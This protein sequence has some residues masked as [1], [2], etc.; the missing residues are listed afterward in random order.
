MLRLP[1]HNRIPRTRL[2]IKDNEIWGSLLRLWLYGP[3]RG[4]SVADF[5]K[6]FAA[7]FAVNRAVAGPYARVCLYQILKTLNLPKGSEIITTPITIHDMINVIILAGYRPVF[8]DIDPRT[9]QMDPE[10]LAQATTDKS[11]AVLLT[12]LFGMPSDMDRIMPICDRHGLVLIEDAS[13][14]FNAAIGGRVVGTFG[15]ASFFPYHL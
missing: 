1:W 3:K 15:A 2:Y 7:M 11:S 10:A 12:H 6:E 8:V 9:Y 4:L 14:S 13:H 5:E